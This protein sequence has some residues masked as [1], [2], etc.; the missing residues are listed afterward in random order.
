[1][2]ACTSAA[3]RLELSCSICAGLMTECAAL[4]SRTGC[5]TEHNQKQSDF[6]TVDF[7]G[8]VTDGLMSEGRRTQPKPRVKFHLLCGFMVAWTGHIGYVGRN[9]LDLSHEL[10]SNPG[11]VLEGQD[12]S[13]TKGF[14]SDHSC[15]TSFT[16]D[17]SLDIKERFLKGLRK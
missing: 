7:S 11:I 1:M 3:A 6:F 16:L 13:I 9:G 4:C 5:G 2:R 12:L 8:P 14:F 17:M 15:S 10:I